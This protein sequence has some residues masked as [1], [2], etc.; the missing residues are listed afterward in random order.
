[1]AWDLL[2][3]KT[4]LA[5]VPDSYLLLRVLKKAEFAPATELK[6]LL[7]H[8]ALHANT[9]KKIGAFKAGFEEAGQVSS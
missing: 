2:P 5:K 1:M 7:L 6:M 8:F 3:L 9:K 4:H